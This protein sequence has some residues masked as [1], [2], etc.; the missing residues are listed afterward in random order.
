MSFTVSRGPGTGGGSRGPGTGGGVKGSKF[1][2]M[3][4]VSQNASF[5]AYKKLKDSG[6]LKAGQSSRQYRG[7]YDLHKL[8]I[9]IF[10]LGYM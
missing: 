3:S 10:H 9:S 7:Q 4:G 1:R 5:Q 6:M 8:S 2:P